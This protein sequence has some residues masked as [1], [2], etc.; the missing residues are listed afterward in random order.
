MKNWPIMRLQFGPYVLNS[1]VRQKKDATAREAVA[2]NCK[3]HLNVRW[4]IDKIRDC[5]LG[6]FWWK[7]VNCNRKFDIRADIIMVYR[8]ARALGEQRLIW[9]PT[10]LCLPCHIATRE[11]CILVCVPCGM[12]RCF[13][14][15]HGVSDSKNTLNILPNIPLNITTNCILVC[16]P[17]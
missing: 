4:K 13:A 3:L 2:R 11:N 5:N 7:I 6:T 16:A 8:R 12:R 14:G 17:L 10:Q 15:A 1:N 9:S